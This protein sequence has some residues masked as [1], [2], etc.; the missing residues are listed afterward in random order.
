M[1]GNDSHQKMQSLSTKLKM[2]YQEQQKISDEIKV[3]EAE[4]VSLSCPFSVGDELEI[5]G[6][7]RDTRILIE[8]I[9]PVYWTQALALPKCDSPVQWAIYGKRKNLTSGQ[10]SKTQ[11]ETVFESSCKIINPACVELVIHDLNALLDVSI[12]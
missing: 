2:L 3:A 6:G 10:Y 5:L 12:T 11:S 1:D 9:Y 4:Y 8:K 7:K